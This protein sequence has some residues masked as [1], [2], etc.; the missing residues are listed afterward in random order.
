MAKRK[1]DR[2][3]YGRTSLMSQAMVKAQ[4]ADCWIKPNCIIAPAPLR[5]R[6]SGARLFGRIQNRCAEAVM[7]IFILKTA[8]S[9]PRLAPECSEAARRGSPSCASTSGRCSTSTKIVKPGAICRSFLD[10]WCSVVT[11][12]HRSAANDATPFSPPAEKTLRML[13]QS[14]PSSRR[15]FGQL[16]GWRFAPSG[17]DTRQGCT[18]GYLALLR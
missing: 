3:V 10:R 4:M 16:R 18:I 1:A 8:R 5:A 12:L 11:E 17:H 15:P 6:E 7:P 14:M 13:T 2:V 9:R